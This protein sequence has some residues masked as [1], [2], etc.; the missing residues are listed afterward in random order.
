MERSDDDLDKPRDS[1]SFYPILPE[2]PS[3]ELPSSSGQ[4]RD[5][6]EGFPL[7]KVEVGDV[8]RIPAEGVSNLEEEW[9][10]CLVGC[11]TGRFPGIKAIEG[12]ISSWHLECKLYP[13]EKGWVIFQFLSD[14]DRRKVLHNGPYVLYGK[15]LLLRI[16][17]EGFRFDFDAFM[18]VDMWVKYVDVPL[19]LRNPVAFECLG[20]RVGTPIRTDGGTK[21]K[22]RLSYCRML[23]RVDMSKELPTSFVV[24]LPDGE[25][26]TQ[27]V[28]YEGLPNYCFHCKKFGHNQLSCRVLRA[29]NHRKSGNYFDKRDGNNLGKDDTVRKGSVTPGCHT[30]TRSFLRCLKLKETKDLRNRFRFFKIGTAINSYTDPREWLHFRQFKKPNRN[31]VYNGA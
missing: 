3:K 26:F 22:G 1:P 20:S 27:K 9:G 29:L 19:Q 31:G 14:E 2:P 24:S 17:P 21:N 11:F 13:H 5:P 15:T 4:N 16:L 12:L 23:I 28:V 18:T 6:S 10:F 30:Q 8:V 7:K 25:E